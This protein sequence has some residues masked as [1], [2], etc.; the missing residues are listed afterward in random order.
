MKGA[1]GILASDLRVSINFEEHFSSIDDS[2]ITQ[3]RIKERT[4][5]KIGWTRIDLTLVDTNGRLE[6]EVELEIADTKHIMSFV[7]DPLNMKKK[8]R[9][10]LLN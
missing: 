9:K 3:I 2:P 6:Y 1:S 5:F 7:N 10:F 8:I 4:S